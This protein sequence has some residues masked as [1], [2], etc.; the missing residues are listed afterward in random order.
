[1]GM[2]VRITKAA[3]WI[4]SLACGATAQAAMRTRTNAPV[5]GRVVQVQGFSKIAHEP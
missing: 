2:W 5:L 1:M 3:W 4:H